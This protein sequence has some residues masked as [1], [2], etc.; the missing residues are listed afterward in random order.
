[1]N[2]LLKITF[3]V[4]FITHIPITLLL[5]LQILL[6]RYYPTTLRNVFTWYIS[7]FNDRL[8]ATRPIWLQ[9]F[10]FA[11]LVLQLPFFFVAVYG[12]SF[13]KKWIRIPAVVYGS[14]VATTVLPILAEVAFSTEISF[15]EKLVLCSVYLPYFLIPAAL[16]YVFGV[17]AD[18][19][20]QSKSKKRN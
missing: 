18:P 1:M 6:G 15:N 16:I 3:L 8:L 7:V 11:E 12:I 4:Y 9:S 13:E 10:I 5:D 20:A 2:Q 14:H 19:F 17:S